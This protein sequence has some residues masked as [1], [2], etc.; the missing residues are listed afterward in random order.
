MATFSALL[1]VVSRAAEGEI[2]DAALEFLTEAGVNPASVLT[3]SIRKAF[4]Y[5]LGGVTQGLSANRIQ[6]MLTSVDLGVR[7]SNLLTVIGLLR[8]SYGFPSTLR[9]VDAERFP[10]ADLF[11]FGYLGQESNFNHV[12][13]FLTRSSVT[14]EEF[15]NHLTVTSDTLLSNEQLQTAVDELSLQS[16]YGVADTL[17]AWDSVKVWVSPTYEP[18]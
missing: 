16:Q 9:G 8:T 5:I 3:S 6:S 11:R 18:L 10:G 17:V 13:K 4:P 1:S 12:I 15:T 7:R 14:G 2:A